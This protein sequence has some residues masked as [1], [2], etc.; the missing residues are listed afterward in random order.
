MDQFDLE[1]FLKNNWKGLLLLLGAGAL[2]VW[3]LRQW[4]RLAP[5]RLDP[6]GGSVAQ[7]AGG[8]VD[9]K[10]YKRY[11]QEAYSSLTGW[12]FSTT[13]PTQVYNRISGLTDNEL[14]LMVNEYEALFSGDPDYPT[15]RVL[16]QSE[17]GTNF[18]SLFG[19]SWLAQKTEILDRLTQIGA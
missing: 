13:G 8:G 6:A 16:I 3:I 11:A 15:L 14:R 5:L 18:G 2:A 7:T 9:T 19:S 12:N 4:N 1:E 17:I 10:L